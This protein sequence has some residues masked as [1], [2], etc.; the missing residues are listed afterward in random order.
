MEGNFDEKVV[1]TLFLS[2]PIF[3]FFF[4]FFLTLQATKRMFIPR[5]VIMIQMVGMVMMNVHELA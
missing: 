2:V 4:F 1:E 5:L 3:F